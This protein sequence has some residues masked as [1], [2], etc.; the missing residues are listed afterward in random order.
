MD[1]LIIVN[2]KDSQIRVKIN[3]MLDK[4]NRLPYNCQ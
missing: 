1:D 3:K 4:Y 2:K